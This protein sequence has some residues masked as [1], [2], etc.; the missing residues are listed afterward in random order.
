M[1]FTDFL[2]SHNSSLDV[3]RVSLL[4][5]K[6]SQIL[7][8]NCF[9][10][11]SFLN[12]VYEDSKYLLLY[13]GV[14]VSR[15]LLKF[16]QPSI[17]SSAAAAGYSSPCYMYFSLV[18][19]SDRRSLRWRPAFQASILMPLKGNT[20]RSYPTILHRQVLSILNNL[21]ARKKIIRR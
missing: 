15:V 1:D 3:N 16:F 14:T 19:K 17:F 6:Q 11:T 21:L 4:Q 10:I 12:I 2:V 18:P 20:S 13:Q 8:R 7:P 5:N 9:S